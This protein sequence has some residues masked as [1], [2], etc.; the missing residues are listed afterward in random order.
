MSSGARKAIF[1]TAAALLGA[2]IAFDLLVLAYG[3]SPVRLLTLLVQGTWGSPYGIGQV[4][5]KATP[6]LFAGLAVHVGL[7]AGLFNIGAEGQITVASLGVAVLAAKLPPQ[8]PAALAVGCSLVAA[9]GFG[10]AWAYLPAILRAHYGAH[11]VISTIMMNRL[12][13]AC[14]G[15]GF[16]YGLSRPDTIR[17]PDIAPAARIPR[18]ESAIPALAGSAAS[19][20]LVLAVAMTALVVWAGRRTYLGREMALLA[21]NPVACA[22]ERIPVQRRLVQALAVS[23]AIAALVSSGT[24]LGYKGY[25][26]R[27]LG[28]GAGFTGLAVALLGR[29]S[30]IGL[31]LAALLFGTL[32]Q[33]GLALN[34]YVPMEV[35]DVIQAVVIVAVAL[36][37]VRIRSLIAGSLRVAVAR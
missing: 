31:V 9:A 7:R 8:M 6:L 12:A 25:Y 24:V 29:E 23:G 4:L 21:Q 20:A 19:M 13:E 37:D 28:A 33:G 17:T 18:L 34:A 5:F 35:M 10:A 26:E 16:A 14:A 36:A 30:A 3:E 2:W 22:A 1:S 32:A 11:E 15:L 27:G